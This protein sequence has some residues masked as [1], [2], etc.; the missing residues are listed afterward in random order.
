MRDFVLA[1]L[2]LDPRGDRPSNPGNHDKATVRIHLGAA[3]RTMRRHYS[4]HGVTEVLDLRERALVD[5]HRAAVAMPVNGWRGIN[6]IN[7]SLRQ[8]HH[9]PV[10]PVGSVARRTA[11]MNFSSK[12]WRRDFG[13]MRRL[14]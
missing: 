5:R 9:R 14:D 3:Q 12:R 10:P 6:G 2:R 7:G 4:V 13:R 11:C 1:D 8:G